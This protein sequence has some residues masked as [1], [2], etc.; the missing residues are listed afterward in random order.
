M[1]HTPKIDKALQRNYESEFPN[2]STQT[3]FIKEV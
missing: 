1:L 3:I 2:C